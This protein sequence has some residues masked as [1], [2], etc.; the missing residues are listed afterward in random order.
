MS[1]QQDEQIQ[2]TGG[3]VLYSFYTHMIKKISPCNYRKGFIC[4][5]QCF[6]FC[7]LCHIFYSSLLYS[8]YLSMLTYSCAEEYCKKTTLFSLIYTQKKFE[9]EHQWE[10]FSKKTHENDET[11]RVFCF[12]LHWDKCRLDGCTI[13]YL[14]LFTIVSDPLML[15]L[16]MHLKKDDTEKMVQN[17]AQFLP[18][19]TR[20]NPIIMNYFFAI[21][22]HM[23]IFLSVFFLL[24]REQNIWTSAD[25]RYMS[26]WTWIIKTESLRH[27]PVRLTSSLFF[28]LCCSHKVWKLLPKIF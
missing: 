15:F 5:F 8:Y 23:V 3:C 24:G 28:T 2:F 1:K 27:R 9:S 19:F 25:S 22:I 26:D 10:K 18:Y 4:M 14:F 11:T 6:L 20:Y 16:L 21:K 13:A 12:S 17:D 7:T